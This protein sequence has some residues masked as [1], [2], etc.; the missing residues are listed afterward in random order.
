MP[1]LVCRALRGAHKVPVERRAELL[2]VLREFYEQENGVEEGREGMKKEKEEEEKN[3]VEEAKEKKE[4]GKNKQLEERE[5]EE[6]D[7]EEEKT[8]KE[9]AEEEEDEDKLVQFALNFQNWCDFYVALI[10]FD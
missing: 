9:K 3:E 5:E 4:V 2:T 10:L 7:E 8:E 6:E 1:V